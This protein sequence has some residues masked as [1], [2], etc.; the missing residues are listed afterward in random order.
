MQVKLN[1][2][3]VRETSQGKSF[4]VVVDE[5]QNLDEPC[6]KWCACS[7]TSRRRAKS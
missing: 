7:P 4:V 6:S 5:A 1:E 3:L 2:C